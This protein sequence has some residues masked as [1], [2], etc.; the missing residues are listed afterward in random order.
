VEAYLSVLDQFPI[1][2]IKFY[3]FNWFLF[4][5]WDTCPKI[6]TLGTGTLVRRPNFF[7]FFHKIQN[8]L[9]KKCNN[10]FLAKSYQNLNRFQ[11]YQQQKWWKIKIIASHFICNCVLCILLLKNLQSYYFFYHSKNQKRGTQKWCY[12][13]CIKCTLVAHTNFFTLTDICPSSSYLVDDIVISKIYKPH[14]VDVIFGR[15][16]NERIAFFQVKLNIYLM[17]Q[18]Y[19]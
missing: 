8:E 15:A 10:I 9:I 12:I 5:N 18:I 16:S 11:K 7:I 17:F 13:Q 6:G 14:F 19:N 4:A 1:K 2:I 3:I